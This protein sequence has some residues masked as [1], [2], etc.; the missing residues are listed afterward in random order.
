[1]V[2]FAKFLPE[3]LL[4]G[5]VISLSDCRVLRPYLLERA[6]ISDGSVIMLAVPY[7]VPCKTRTVSMYAVAKDYHA[8]FAMLF[9]SVLSALRTEYPDHVFAGFADHS[10]IAEVET[11]CKA[12]LGVMG[13]NGLLLTHKHSSYVFLGEIITSM[14]CDSSAQPISHCPDCGACRRACPV[15]LTKEQCLSDLTQKKGALDA[16][17]IAQLRSHPY[18]WGCDICQDA[19]PFTA[20]AKKAGTLYT[21]VPYFQQD[22]IPSPDLAILRGMS[23][24]DF[25]HRAY[26]WRGRH[27]IC[28]NIMIKEEEQ[29]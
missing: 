13:S 5:S 26:S 16:Q 2:N 21:T 18:V 23:D 27:T 25:S 4:V 28:R 17:E 6:G 19:C 15:D 14:P 22:L 9:E 12:G 3:G 29:A 8:Y 7:A 1:M 10:P 11:A 24:E 20:A